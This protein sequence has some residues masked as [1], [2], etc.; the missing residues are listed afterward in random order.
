MV[1]FGFDPVNS[2]LHRKRW[3]IGAGIVALAVIFD[4]N[5]SSLGMWNSWLGMPVGQDVV[6]GTPRAIRSDE[7]SVG[8][9]F[10]FSQY[11]NEYAY[12]NSYIGDKA[13]DMFIIK[14]APVAVIAEL[15][16]P[17]HW[18]FLVFG[19][20]RGLAFYW[21]ARMVLLFLLAYQ[22]MMLLTKQEIQSDGGNHRLS[23]LGASLVS[24][25]PIVQWWFA[26][27]NLVEMLIAMF[28]AWISLNAYLN[29]R[30]FL[31]RIAW[32]SLIFICAGAFILALYPAW[33]IPL[34]YLIV[35][36]ALWIII[37]NRGR[38]HLSLL[39][40]GG[41][42][43]VFAIFVVLILTVVINSWETIH[44]MLNTVYPGERHETGGGYPSYFL[45]SGVLSSAFGIKDFPS[46]VVTNATEA[47]AFLDLFPLGIF[48]TIINWCRKKKADLLEAI[49]LALLFFFIY[50]M[51]FGLPDFLASITFL[52]NVQ[53]TRLLL[54]TGIINIFLIVRGAYFF[55]TP[56]KQWFITLVILLLSAYSAV[57]AFLSYP[58][59]TG[60][61]TM[62]GCFIFTAIITL[63][64]LA[65][66]LHVRRIVTVVAVMGIVASGMT[67]NPIQLSSRA[68]TEQPL[69]R[70][71]ETINT[72]DNALWLVDGLD[73]GRVSQLLVA[74]GI[75][76]INAL[77]VT[78]NF[79]LWETI[80]PTGRYQDVY[81][82]FAFTSV[83][84][85]DN[86]EENEKI[87]ELAAPDFIILNLSPDELAKLGVRYVVSGAE[88]EDIDN[89]SFIFEKVGEIQS[90]RK[91]F[92]LIAK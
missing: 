38:I 90:G 34:V 48:L 50:F 36:V 28:A 21:S 39:D 54:V 14:D 17:F 5:G 20:S 69:V 57:S 67:V 27:N 13:S 86:S 76:T 43:V 77:S 61:W 37:S 80:D 72:S 44:A 75:T 92:E 1:Y 42:L 26:V 6:F 84:I 19:S 22:F 79:K 8:T 16:R 18:G 32:A 89:P 74:N 88:L 63:A 55:N 46:S 68:I 83:I 65:S 91:I 85:V 60:L 30:G 31:Q 12:F 10:A 29:S 78:P 51:V 52:S 11:H 73:G 40:I 3:W 25:A 33:Q 7:F 62:G 87:A 70:E 9:P 41:L 23:V 15:F 82:R 2:F 35:F 56:K 66:G 58:R 49:L 64:F 45:G 71:I 4:V 24:F 81:N 59:Y 47:A 53:P